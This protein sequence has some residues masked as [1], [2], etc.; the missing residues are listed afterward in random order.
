MKRF[1][2]Y[3][4]YFVTIYLLTSIT[5]FGQF[6]VPVPTDRHDRFGIY[7][8]DFNPIG[9]PTGEN[10]LNWGTTL[11]ASLNSRTARVYLCASD[12][13]HVN[14]VNNTDDIDYLV[15][16]AQTPQ[17]TSFF[18]DSRFTTYIITV[19]TVN[20]GNSTFGYQYEKDRIRRLGEHL[21]NTVANPPFS[22]KNFI[23]SNWEGDDL[24]SRYL[25][26]SRVPVANQVPLMNGYVNW[27]QSRVDGVNEAKIN[28]P[29]SA[30]K[31][32]SGLEIKTVYS[33][34][35]YTSNGTPDFSSSNTTKCGQAGPNGIANCVI[36]Y[37]A[38]K[39]KVDYIL[40]SC[41][42]S[43]N[44]TN[45]V[46]GTAPPYALPQLKTR[47]NDDVNYLLSVANQ[48]QVPDGAVYTK[49]NFI[50]GEFGFDNLAFNDNTTATYTREMY[51]IVDE[52]G[53]PFAI[54]WQI[55]DSLGSPSN[56]APTPNTSLYTFTN[57]QLIK[58]SSGNAFF[59]EISKPSMRW[60]AAAGA[61]SSKMASAQWGTDRV[62][63]F[64]RGTDNEI[65]HS[66]V[67]TA[68]NIWNGFGGM[69]LKGDL[70]SGAAGA[71][72]VTSTGTWA[73]G[74]L[75]VFV[76]GANNSIYHTASVN[77]GAYQIWQSFGGGTYSDPSATA[78]GTDRIDMVVRG[79][80]DNIYHGI[81]YPATNTF[82]GWAPL[83]FPL[84]AAGSPTLISSGACCSGRLD[85]FVRA[86]NGTIWQLSAINGGWQSWT[87]RDGIATSDIAATS[88]G[89]DRI[90]VYVRGTDNDIYHAW[91]Q[92]S[93]NSWH[94][95]GG[96]NLQGTISTGAVGNPVVSALGSS[97][98]GR[99]DLYTRGSDACIYHY[100][101]IVGTAQQSWEKLGGN[102]LTDPATA[103]Q[104]N[105]KLHLFITS[106]GG[107]PF[108][109]YY[110]S[111]WKP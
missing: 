5:I 1:I 23:F 31:L 68:T 33:P 11:T 7:N 16:I 84:Q 77:G 95:F 76:R 39:V 44:P 64:V 94:T 73:S 26:T 83:N 97:S 49:K 14:P 89:N 40:Y 57:G 53:V 50:L 45:W 52:I 15:R 8:W 10:T 66:W 103:A 4:T 28:S 109:K 63:A 22:G 35:G 24:F 106:T 46:G 101:Q 99:L 107:V 75:D 3:L 32:F 69:N 70:S 72:V 62:D 55:K 59:D 60:E 17:Y 30:A 102:A 61:G 81:Y 74:R 21:L 34:V 2:R 110:D 27:I 25:D 67:Q 65:Y 85:L 56:P 9:M 41:W 6:S 92:P 93:T 90:D 54:F 29:N 47:L 100:A 88:W 38:T 48:R 51:K 71:P 87:I 105:N 13:Y 79:T 108:R 42:Q 78:W 111:Y 58:T 18:S 86:T 36:N 91:Q 19:Y 43:I 104:S 37:V 96:I 80:D 20:S 98:A 82:G 12:P